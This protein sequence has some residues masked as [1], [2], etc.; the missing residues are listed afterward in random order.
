MGKKAGTGCKQKPKAKPAVGSAAKRR[1]E[2][3]KAGVPLA[4]L[5]EQPKGAIGKK[6]SSAD[7]QQHYMTRDAAWRLRLSKAAAATVLAGGG[8]LAEAARAAQA[9]GS[10]G[11][12][13]DSD[14]EGPVTPVPKT[15]PRGMDEDESAT[16]EADEEQA[17]C[18]EPQPEP[19]VAGP[20]PAPEP[21]TQAEAEEEA[22]P[23][24]AEP[25]PLR[26]GPCCEGGECRSGQF[27]YQCLQRNG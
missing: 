2:A 7:G 11:Q 24:T 3:A 10:E 25:M 13:G 22:L 15:L 6:A 1:R 14:D 18:I 17:I 21:G 4:G 8:D 5:P 19:E 27:C 20:E 12:A 16:A 26:D 23:A 9:F